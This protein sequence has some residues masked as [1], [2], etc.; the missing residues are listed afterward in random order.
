MIRPA[1]KNGHVDTLLAVIRELKGNEAIHLLCETI[2][3]YEKEAALFLIREAHIDPNAMFLRGWTP[4][5]L[6][7]LYGM[8]DLV[9]HLVVEKRMDVK[10]LDEFGMDVMYYAACGGVP[11]IVSL[12]ME[13]A[14]MTV[15]RRYTVHEYTLLH[16]AA[17]R[18]HSDLVQFLVEGGWIDPDSVDADLRKSL[19][20]AL[21]DMPSSKVVNYLKKR[22]NL[23]QVSKVLS[24]PFI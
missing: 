19:D 11:E 17:Q 4:L 3:M 20:L 23:G 8:T 13:V 6:A 22:G 18:G 15:G 16:I 21:V 5:M 10:A 24:F 12:L 2:M 9:R 7:A 14:G 1:V